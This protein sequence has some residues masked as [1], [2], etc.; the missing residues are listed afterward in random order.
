MSHSSPSSVETDCVC[1]FIFLHWP[2]SLF[3]FC[4]LATESTR[5]WQWEA[6]VSALQNESTAAPLWQ[7][8]LGGLVSFHELSC[9]IKSSDCTFLQKIDMLN[10]YIP[11]NFNFLRFSHDI[12]WVLIMP[13]FDLKSPILLPQTLLENDQ[14][15]FYLI[16]LVE[17][18]SKQIWSGCLLLASCLTYSRDHPVCFWWESQLMFV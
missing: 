15:S 9:K 1:P 7:T 4:A 2:L 8:L 12:H 3:C 18:G 17:I 16:S 6:A 5:L 11:L 14:T 13:C 10:I